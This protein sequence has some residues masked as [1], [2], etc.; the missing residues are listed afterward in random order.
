[1]S[2]QNNSDKNN[3]RYS[4]FLGIK[5]DRHL[6]T[7]QAGMK[8]FLV[9]IVFS[10]VSGFFI[11]SAFSPNRVAQQIEHAASHIHK[12]LKV[13]FKEAQFSLSNGILPRFSIVV[14]NVELQ[15]ID[16]CA[17]SSTIV[18]DE[19]RLPLSPWGLLTGK[20]AI[21][22]VDAEQVSVRIAGKSPECIN[23]KKVKEINSGKGTANVV[24]LAPRDEGQKYKDAVDEMSIG[25]LKIFLSEYPQYPLEFMDLGIKVSSFEPRVIQAKAKTHLLHDENVGGYLS[26]ANVFAEYKEAADPQIQTHVFGNWREGH[27]SVIANYNI[28]DHFLNIESDVKHIPFSQVLTLL[29]KYKLAS[30]DLKSKQVWISGVAHIAGE[31]EKLKKNPLDVRNFLVEG[32]FGEISSTQMDFMSLEPLAYK[33]V[34]LELNKINIHNFLSFLNHNPSSKFLGDLGSFTGELDIFSENSIRLVGEH[35]GLEFIFSNKGQRELQ[36]IDRMSGEASFSGNQWSFAIKKIEPREGR[37]NGSI[38]F[39]SDRDFNDMTVA[40]RIDDLVL[41][42]QVQKLMT[43]GGAIGGVTFHADAR[44]SR[45]RLSHIKGLVAIDNMNVE[46]I[47]L[48]KTHGDFALLDDMM[49]LKTRVQDVQISARSAGSTVMT[50]IVPADWWKDSKLDI[51]DLAGQFQWKDLAHFQWRSFQGKVGK[52]KRIQVDGGWDETGHLKG[53]ATIRDGKISKKFALSGDRENPSFTAEHAEDRLI[54]KK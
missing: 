34:K 4:P 15:F 47:S 13:S 33:P 54:I 29:Q 12:D 40:T 51:Q 37:L 38:N 2:H 14:S 6:V 21:K 22:K 46:G 3:K 10:F 42:P 18:I 39:K 53:T 35:K 32:D 27:Y 9:G 19:L 36:I 26:Y 7:E 52:S 25:N 1:M 5:S 44:M 11:K 23:V 24:T 8:V 17:V 41:A 48:E 31:V 50:Q 16:L 28:S 30:K 45:G 43:N 20:P 49:I